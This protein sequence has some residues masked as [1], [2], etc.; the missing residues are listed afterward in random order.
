MAGTPRTGRQSRSLCGDD[1]SLGTTGTPDRS[2]FGDRR[3]DDWFGLAG[4]RGDRACSWSAVGSTVVLVTDWFSVVQ[5]T[6]GRFSGLFRAGAG[7]RANEND[8]SRDGDL[9][10]GGDD[11][12]VARDVFAAA[13]NGDR[14]L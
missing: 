1:E 8:T 6:V 9:E 2:R 3:G 14:G 5:K 7:G 4:A 12:V 13:A 11:A 10:A